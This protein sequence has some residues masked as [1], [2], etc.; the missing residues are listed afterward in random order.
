MS[1]I[2]SF[3]PQFYMISRHPMSW[4]I[5]LVFGDQLLQLCLLQTSHTPAACSLVGWDEKQKGPSIS[6]S[7]GQ[8]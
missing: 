3:S 5:P 7:T 6:G 2:L 1:V 8:Q 4:N